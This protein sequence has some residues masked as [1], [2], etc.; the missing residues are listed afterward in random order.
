MAWL[1]SKRDAKKTV[2]SGSPREITSAQLQEL[3]Y[4]WIVRREPSIVIGPP[5]VGK[6]FAAKEAAKRAEADKRIRAWEILDGEKELTRERVFERRL[7][8]KPDPPF[9][10]FLPSLVRKHVGDFLL[11]KNVDLKEAFRIWGDNWLLLILDEATRCTNAF[12][13]SCLPVLN[14]FRISNENETWL[15]PVLVILLGNPAGFD[16]STVAFSPALTSRLFQ[17]VTMYQPGPEE[18]AVTY[19][20]PDVRRDAERLGIPVPDSI[21]EYAVVACAVITLLWGLPVE[22]EKRKGMASLSSDA[23]SLLSKVEKAD[24]ELAKLL[25]DIGEVTHFGPDP[26]KGRRWLTTALYEAHHEGIPFGPGHLIDTA[27][28][29]LSVGG[30]D[31]FSEGQEPHLQQRKEALIQRIAEHM[32]GS[33]EKWRE[34]IQACKRPAPDMSEPAEL[35]AE[36]APVLFTDE[37]AR[38][39]PLRR[40]LTEHRRQLRTELVPDRESRSRVLAAFLNSVA[41]LD[42]SLPAAELERAVRELAARAD[43]KMLTGDGFVCRPDR[44]LLRQLSSLGGLSRIGDALVALL[45]LEGRPVPVAPEEEVR[46]A[47][48]RFPQAKHFSQELLASVKR[49]RDLSDRVETA[50]SVLAA[51]LALQPGEDVRDV[52]RRLFEL[53]P[54]PPNGNFDARPFFGD[55]FRAVQQ[56][57]RRPYIERFE[58]LCHLLENVH[59]LG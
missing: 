41:R 21:E 59:E 16:A 42:T 48:E 45:Q 23:R 31:T 2:A 37:A 19:T 40:L 5:G 26:R 14:E 20:L 30:K 34:L 6:T 22:V 43:A 38:K 32:L 49:H 55:L 50:A 28:R 10:G 13:D 36:M 54:L 52:A 15:A 46:L 4:G 56:Q 35:A 9:F 33:N 7:I 18:L 25:K 27:V 44:D 8:E 58:Q 11:P 24:P 17:R 12:L 29:C 39:E 51:A 53:F 57:A 47:C 1:G 3:A